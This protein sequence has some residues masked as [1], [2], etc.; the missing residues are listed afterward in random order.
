MI[1]DEAFLV[2]ATNFDIWFYVLYMIFTYLILKAIYK[3]KSQIIDIFI[4]IIASLIM[5]LI[6]FIVYI[7]IANT[8]KQFIAYAIIS[9]ILLFMLLFFIRNKLYNI[10]KLYRKLWNRHDNIPKK[11]KT[12]TFR[13][14]NI[15]IFNITFYLVHLILL[16]E[17]TRI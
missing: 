2:K 7:I 17:M 1:I 16:F 4:F 12:T 15:V 13:S 8:I 14:I 11:I 6:N 10:T 3:E 5:L 9:R